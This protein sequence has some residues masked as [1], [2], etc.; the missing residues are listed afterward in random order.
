M[1]KE[2][3][4]LAT[5]NRDFYKTIVKVKKKSGKPFKSGIRIATVKSA[6]TNPNTGMPAYTFEEDNSV[7]DIRQLIEISST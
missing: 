3:P 2:I 1:Q 6:T 7:V 4:N 5:D